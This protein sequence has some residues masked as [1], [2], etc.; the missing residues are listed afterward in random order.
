MCINL[1]A[2]ESVTTMY[3][4]EIIEFSPQPDTKQDLCRLFNTVVTNLFKP[5]VHDLDLYQR[6][7]LPT[8]E[9]IEEDCV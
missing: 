8:E 7:N 2:Q 5:K 6:Q 3:C 4:L 1:L 9:F